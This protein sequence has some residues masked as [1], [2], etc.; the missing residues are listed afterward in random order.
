LKK[1]RAIRIITFLLFLASVCTIAAQEPGLK[2]I[3]YNEYYNYPISVGVDYSTFNPFT[4]YGVDTF[5]YEFGFNAKYP[6][7]FNPRIVPLVRLGMTTVDS[8]D[9]IEPEKWDHKYY[10]ASGGAQYVNR[11]NKS[12]EMGGGLSGG[13]AQGIFTGLDNENSYGAKNIFGSLM[14]VMGLNPSYNMN[15]SITPELKYRYFLN[16]LDK[17]NG[18]SFGIGFGINYRFGLDPDS[19]KT[20]IKSIRLLKADIPPVFAAMQSYY[21]NNPIGS[22]IIRNAEDFSIEDVEISFYQAGFM[23]TPATITAIPEI[24]KGGEV[25]VDLPVTFNNNVFETEGITPLN[26]EIII[27]YLSRTRGAKQSFPVKYELHDKT[28][29][30]WTDDR[31]VGAFI[32]PADSALRNYSSYIKQ[33]TKDTVNSGFSEKLQ[34]GLQIYYGLKEIGCLY[35]VDPTSPFISAQ[36]NALVVDSINLARTTLKR[37]VGD[38]DDLTVLYSSL[39]ETLGIETAFITIPGHIY[40]AFN[41]GIPSRDYLKVHPDKDMTIN[42]NGDLWIPVEITMVGEK[43]FMTAWKKGIDEYRLYDDDPEK[44]A[45]NLTAKAQ[46]VYRPVSLKET[47][48]GLQYGDK[49]NIVKGVENNLDHLID[50]VISH[51]TKAAE[52]EDTKNSFNKLGILAAKYGRYE[53]SEDSF[54][55][56]LNKDKNYIQPKINVGNLFFL[57][58]E[59]ENALRNYHRAENE[60][61]NLNRKKSALYVKVVLNISRSYYELEEYERAGEYY[62]AIKEINPELAD[63]FNYLGKIADDGSRA[64]EVSDGIGVLFGDDSDS[65]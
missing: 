56:A 41:T 32:T 1:N 54:N 42:L 10:Y 52:K 12:F 45:F 57:Q 17:F 4:D 37:A 18:L 9:N 43:D 6:L 25:H 13:F 19:P 60:L 65:M 14:G 5:T 21:V 63:K 49:N 62:Q 3:D 64:A 61:E 40:A 29:L 7:P 38:C 53:V 35:Q 15:I 39:L 47:D 20:I 24:K 36:G 26:G 59:F 30:T 27:E 31:K 2:E 44:R 22:I 51:Y 33:V 46:V 16:P 8:K 34:S 28:S 48:L 58:Q 23:D 50:A 11:I 55:R